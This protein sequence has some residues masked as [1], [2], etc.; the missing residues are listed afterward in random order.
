ME[1][2]SLRN[3]KILATVYTLISLFFQDWI[4][5]TLDGN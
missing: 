3:L 2:L 5:V 4:R 1:L